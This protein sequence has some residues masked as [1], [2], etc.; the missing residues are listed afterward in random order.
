M[1]PW[2]EGVVRVLRICLKL[3]R[4]AVGALS[5]ELSGA[6][7]DGVWGDLGWWRVSLPMAGVQ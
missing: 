5:L 3:S 2:D 4:E 7:L 6:G 1:P